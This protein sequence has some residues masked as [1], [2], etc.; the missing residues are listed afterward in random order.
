[1][2]K[3]Q[4]F[5]HFSSGQA[6]VSS[7]RRDKSKIKKSENN[8]WEMQSALAYDCYRPC[9]APYYLP[10]A[11]PRWHSGKKSACLPIQETQ[12]MRV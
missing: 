1:M 6:P 5:P 7:N 11:L 8:P 9:K 4:L 2:M 3:L 10:T 12:D